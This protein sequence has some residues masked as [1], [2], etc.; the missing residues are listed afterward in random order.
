METVVTAKGRT[1]EALGEVQT[2][3]LGEVEEKGPL[4]QATGVED[5]VA[6]ERT[7]KG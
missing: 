1:T 3:T 6:T 2:E 7:G 4:A 5:Q